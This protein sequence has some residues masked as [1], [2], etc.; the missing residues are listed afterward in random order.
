MNKIYVLFFLFIFTNLSYSW[1]TNIKLDCINE[2]LKQCS[3]SDTK[4]VKSDQISGTDIKI[5]IEEKKKPIKK[6]FKKKENKKINRDKLIVKKK[7]VK[8][9]KQIKKIDKIKKKPL[10]VAKSKIKNVSFEEFKN[11]VINY[12]NN[13]GYPDIDN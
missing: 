2:N 7:V 6:V 4:S 9:E 3:S 1:E 5:P 8:N 10:K 11:S 12:S 13:T